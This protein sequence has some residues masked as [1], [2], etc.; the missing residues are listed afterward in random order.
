MQVRHRLKIQIVEQNLRDDR[1]VGFKRGHVR[2]GGQ[3]R[4][5]LGRRGE[6]S[7]EHLA[8]ETRAA[9]HLEVDHYL[10]GLARLYKLQQPV[11]RNRWNGKMLRQNH[12][13]P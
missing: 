10:S 13:I 11:F 12:G 6:G 9:D 4:T 3:G 1:V 5:R 8:G 2:I 7:D